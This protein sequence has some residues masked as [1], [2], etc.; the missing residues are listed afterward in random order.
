MNRIQ[1][2]VENLFKTGRDTGNLPRCRTRW[3]KFAMQTQKA[4]VGQQQHLSHAC[5]CALSVLPLKG[6]GETLL[7]RS[8][9]GSEGYKQ[10]RLHHVWLCGVCVLP[11]KSGVDWVIA[12]I[13]STVSATFSISLLAFSLRFSLRRIGELDSKTK[14]DGSSM[15]D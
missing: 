2:R 1:Y 7:D 10:R 11:S 15:T 4:K 12:T 6:T 8:P 13:E 5:L 9:K 3:Q 14:I